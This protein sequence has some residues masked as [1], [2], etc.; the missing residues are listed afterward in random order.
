MSRIMKFFLGILSTA[1]VA[2]L[3]IAFVPHVSGAVSDILLNGKYERTATILNEQIS[4]AGELTAVKYT[5]DGKLELKV[6]ALLIGQ[7]A[8]AEAPFTYE[9]GLGISLS[10]VEIKAEEWGVIAVVPPARML[11]DSFQ[12]TGDPKISN[13][14]YS[15]STKDYQ[16]ASDQQAAECRASYLNHPSYLDDAW[17]AAC[18]QLSDLFNTW[19]GEDVPVTFEKPAENPAAEETPAATATP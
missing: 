19:I 10:Q 13:S 7:V 11:Y 12:V 14:L 9:I 18:E 5:Q 1:L 2:T 15:I 17:N 16:N 3:I 4:K 8:S 6:N